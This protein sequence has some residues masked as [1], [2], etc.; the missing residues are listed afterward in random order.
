MPLVNLT[1]HRLHVIRE[2]GSVVALPPATT[3]VRAVVE[4]VRIATIEGI[5]ILIQTTTCPRELP[6]PVE[7][8]IYIVSAYTKIHFLDENRPDVLYP[9]PVYRDGSG[10]V[11]ACRG[12]QQMIGDEQ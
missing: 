7:G 8:T 3:T 6:P 11:T 5:E 10:R 4:H 1:G 2:D 12:L 9:G